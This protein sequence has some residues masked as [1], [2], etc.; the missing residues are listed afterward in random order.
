MCVCLVYCCEC[1]HALVCV[2]I[3]EA[4]I[5]VRLETYFEYSVLLLVEQVRNPTI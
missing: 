3:K 5:F 2:L 1:A 4:A